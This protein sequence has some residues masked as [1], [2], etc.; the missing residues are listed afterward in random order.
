[1]TVTEADAEAKRR[2]GPRGWA[3]QWRDGICA[4]GTASTVACGRTF[5]EAFAW[6]ASHGGRAA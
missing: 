3:R 5:E 1:M 2:W 6:A 4:V